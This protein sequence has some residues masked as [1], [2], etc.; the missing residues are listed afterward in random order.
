MTRDVP[1]ILVLVVMACAP[2]KEAPPPTCDSS[3]R[4][5]T[6]RV[7]RYTTCLQSELGDALI[8]CEYQKPL[9]PKPNDP[10]WTE[11]APGLTVDE[12]L[13][14]WVPNLD[15]CEDE[16]DRQWKCELR[17]ASTPR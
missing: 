17:V 13:R 1:V 3:P 4:D 7:A 15:A 10:P 16:P 9:V 6:S 8:L 5:Q 11:G 2:P 14:K 12:C